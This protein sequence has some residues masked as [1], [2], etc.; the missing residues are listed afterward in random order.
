MTPS[1]PRPV[2]QKQKETQELIDKFAKDL[3]ALNGGKT[4][5]AQW[6]NYLLKAI[7]P[8]RQKPGPRVD[9]EQVVEIVKRLTLDGGK[10]RQ[11]RTKSYN[12]ATAKAKIAID[13]P[14]TIQPGKKLTCHS[15]LSGCARIL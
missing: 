8:E 6:K 14:D 10:I 1:G 13:T 12:P 7:K 5:P 3:L 15:V 2:T 11:Q 9:Y 4:I